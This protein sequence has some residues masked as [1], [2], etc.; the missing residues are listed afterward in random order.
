MM[1]KNRWKIAAV[2]TA[3]LILAAC[4]TDSSPEQ[5]KGL[6]KTLKLSGQVYTQEFGQT[7]IT[8]KSN[9]N[10]FNGDLDL[11]DNDLGGSGKI[12]NGQ[13]GYSVGTPVLSPVGTGLALLNDMYADISFSTLDLNAAILTLTINDSEDYK[14]QLRE[15][16]GNPKIISLSPLALTFTFEIVNYVYVDKDVTVSANGDTFVFDDFFIPVTLTTGNIKLKLKKGWNPLHST[17]IASSNLPFSPEDLLS[18]DITNLDLT[19]LADLEP[20]G[21]LVMS[22]KDPSSLCWTLR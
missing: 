7:G 11:S 4:P 17:I 19:D 1:K 5:Y 16:L 6:G 2:L 3:V 13:L 8:I 22:L 9:Y 14:M 18:P 21:N 10:K 15:K 12:K 20:T